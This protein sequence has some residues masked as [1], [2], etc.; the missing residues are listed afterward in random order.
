MTPRPPC[1]NLRQ[2]STDPG[3]YSLKHVN[4]NP[5]VHYDGSFGYIGLSLTNMKVY[6][7]SPSNPVIPTVTAS[8][9]PGPTAVATPTPSNISYNIIY[10][11][12]KASTHEHFYTLNNAEGDGVG[13]N[14]EGTAFRLFSNPSA[15]THPLYRCYDTSSGKHFVSVISTCEG[16]TSE[17]VLGYA[18]DE[19]RAGTLQLDRYY[20]TD[21]D[22]FLELGNTGVAASALYR[23]D[24]TLGYAWAP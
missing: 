8:P 14:S 7:Q 16:K 17:G 23:F 9:T 6:L 1:P 12:Y 20:F 21:G 10:R 3:A 13:F 22:H 24:A 2:L 18:G 19:Q 5:E 11:R 15:G 4:L